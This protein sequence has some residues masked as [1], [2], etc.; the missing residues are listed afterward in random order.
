MDCG[1]FDINNW[2]YKFEKGWKI[3][4]K[5]ATDIQIEFSEISEEDMKSINLPVFTEIMNSPAKK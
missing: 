2:F 5:L 3:A 1:K 4:V